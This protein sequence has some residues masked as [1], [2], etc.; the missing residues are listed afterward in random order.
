MQEVM[1]LTLYHASIKGIQNSKTEY[2]SFLNAHGT[3]SRTD[4]ILDHKTSFNKFK[5]IEIP[6]IF[7][8]HNSMKV[9]IIY[10]RKTVK[11][12][13]NVEGN[14]HATKQPMGQ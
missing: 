6:G 5:K 9:E 3:L 4:H 1:S 8:D 10:E 7:S 2:T 11:K 14:Q 13:K 12:H